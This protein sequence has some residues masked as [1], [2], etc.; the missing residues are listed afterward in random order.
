MA[1]IIRSTLIPDETPA[2]DGT[3]S[4]NLPVNPISHIMFIIKCLNVT[5]EATLANI[6]AL[7]TNLTV[8]NRGQSIINLSAADLYA[9]NTVIFP[10]VPVF[11]NL[12]ATDNATRSVGLCIPFGRMLFNPAEC[13]PKSR[14]GELTLSVT[15]DIATAEADGLIL[16]AE[17][18][19]LPEASPKR[20]L[21]ATTMARTPTATGQMDVDLPIGNPLAGILLW[22]T[23][24]P[25]GT[26]WTATIDQFRLLVDNVEYDYANA[27]WEAMHA[28]LV[29]R[30]GMPLGSEDA[31]AND[32]IPNYALVDLSPNKEDL[33]LL[34]T[35]PLASLKARIEAGDTNPLRVIPIELPPAA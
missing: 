8:A 11:T 32:V 2:A 16:L 33:Y 12:V 19:E 17:T 21:K 31:W 26:A 23:T 27:Y 20:Y 18:I 13:F 34:D 25:T 35:A 5:D 28:D 3:Y 10:G 30:G 15:V 1:R 14:E 24:V 9:L 4:Y 29:W 6:L 22:G 7:V